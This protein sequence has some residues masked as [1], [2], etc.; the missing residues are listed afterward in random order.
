MEPVAKVAREL[1]SGLKKAL[2][3]GLSESGTGLRRRKEPTGARG[4][5]VAVGV[6]VAGVVAAVLEALLGLNELANG[7]GRNSLL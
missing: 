6:M 7:F 1:S 5:A 4:L 2:I 3:S